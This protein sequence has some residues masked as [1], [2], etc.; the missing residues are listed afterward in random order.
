MPP[1]FPLTLAL[2]AVAG[3][4]YLAL[5]TSPPGSG[6]A[7]A[8]A[9]K[10]ALGLA[11]L[12]QAGDIAWLCAHGQHP[13][14]NARE[15][16]YFLSFLMVG[17]YLVMSLRIDVPVVGS[18]LVPAAMVLD[19]AARLTPSR[20]AAH[21]STLLA[22]VHITLAS[23]GVAAFA[24]AAAGAVLYLL[25][26]KNLKRHKTGR[27]FGR[28]PALETLDRLNRRCITVGFPLLTVAM[29]T[30]AIWVMRLKGVLLTPQYAMSTVT[31]VLYAIL[32]VARVTAGWRGR[33]AALMTLAGFGA[34]MT[35]LLIYFL[36]GVTGAQI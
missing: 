31:W 32:L 18:L 17:A 26:E 8:H 27:L 23:A 33:R 5:L 16:I 6:R 20:E 10:I 34:A 9:A 7:M 24:V 29:V 25:T 11:F 1:L 3:T 36:R 4:L 21:D 15:A 19:V 12:S 22:S 30:G 13:V 35:V 14:V 2:L 28:G